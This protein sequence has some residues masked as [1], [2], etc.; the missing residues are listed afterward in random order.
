MQHQ[1]ALDKGIFTQLDIAS[2]WRTSLKKNSLITKQNGRHVRFGNDAFPY[3]SKRRKHDVPAR[4]KLYGDFR[5]SIL[6]PMSGVVCIIYPL[7]SPQRQP[8]PWGT[9]RRRF[10][11]IFIFLH[12]FFRTFYFL[13]ASAITSEVMMD[14]SNK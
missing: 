6:R 5:S 4:R 14:T 10:F 8:P 3:R 2:V 7:P 12:T 1:P 9:V 11:S 13:S